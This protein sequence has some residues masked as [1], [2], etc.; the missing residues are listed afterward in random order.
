MPDYEGLVFTTKFPQFR[1]R[2]SKQITLDLKLIRPPKHQYTKFHET[3]FG[4]FFG[5]FVAWWHILKFL[6]N[7]VLQF[8][9]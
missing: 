7:S 3:F 5:V 6:I 2:T 8:V 9:I 4:V 1:N